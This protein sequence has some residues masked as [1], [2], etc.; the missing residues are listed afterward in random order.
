M[1]ILSTTIH[2]I[3]RKW[4]LNVTWGPFFCFTNN[5]SS[6]KEQS[7]RK[8]HK[9]REVREHFSLRFL[10]QQARQRVAC[11]NIPLYF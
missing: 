11:L 8:E 4:F 5:R 9:K 7:L 6:L 1:V 2:Y 3:S 10:N